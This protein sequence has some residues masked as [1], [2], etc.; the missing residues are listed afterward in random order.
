M[1]DNAFTLLAKPIQ[2]VLWDM[3]WTQLRPI[4]VDAVHTLLESDQ[5]LLISARTASGKTEAAFLPI[6]S[7]LYSRP[8]TSVGAIYVGPLKALINDQFG[9]L[10]DL[11]VRTQIPVHRWHGDVD[12]GKKA[13]LIQHPS[14][15]LLITPE[16]LES[17]FVNRPRFLASLFSDL[18]YIV[19]DEIHSLIGRERGLQLKSQLMRLSRYYQQRPRLLGL[20]ATI[21]ES[22]SHYN[23]WL[24]PGEPEKVSFISDPSEEKEILLGIRTFAVES[25]PV[26]ST[27][28]TDGS[29][30]EDVCEPAELVEYIL[31]HFCGRKNLIFCNKSRLEML[32]DEL[33]SACR[34]AAIVAEFLVHHGSLSRQVREETEKD[35]KGQRP[36]TTLCSSTL[37]LGIDIGNIYSVG[38]IGPTWSVSSMVQR[39]GRSGRKDGESQRLRVLIVEPFDDSDKDLHSNLH[40]SLL[41][42]IAIIEL[43][44]ENWVEPPTRDL[45][46]LSTLTQQIL[47]CLAETGGMDAKSIFERLA[48]HGPFREFS[49]A[50]FA[51]IYRSLAASKL[52]E[53]MED[54]TLILAPDGE[55]LVHSLEFYSAFTA[56]TEYTVRNKGKT[57]GRI[58]ALQIPLVGH[59]FLLGGRRWQVESINV[60]KR[61]VLVHPSSGRKAPPLTGRGGDVHEKVRQKMKAIL[62]SQIEPDYVDASGIELLRKARRTAATAK[63]SDGDV[64]NLGK[65]EC[66]WF[67]WTS[68]RIHA[69]LIWLFEYLQIRV[70]DE[71]EAIRIY[72]SPP[73][74]A[75]LLTSHQVTE[76]TANVLAK[77]ANVFEM[78]KFEKYLSPGLRELAIATDFIDLNGARAV[79]QRSFGN[80]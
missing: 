68:S 72:A 66:L 23:D 8:P 54:G 6:L 39:L 32:A 71:D 18:R 15:V 2:N 12:A 46:D 45:C 9:R 4:Q 1:V 62:L 20:S 30:E 10:E 77:S 65:D 42:A 69:T 25:T 76:L 64:I 73:A 33:N 51:E 22:I 67:T 14:G 17:L 59:H 40:L 35:M 70:S 43:M 5:H 11:C 78:R 80:R 57:I 16:S 48:V 75:T 37:E 63:L 29:I 27:L 44:R 52:I 36:F 53:Q 55:R 74:L 60:E 61:E 50:T 31:K 28:P 21:G 34:K 56:E 49:S 58:S 41:Q 79:I 26:K 13:K 3:K 7:D 47:S 38:Q 24:S 19:I